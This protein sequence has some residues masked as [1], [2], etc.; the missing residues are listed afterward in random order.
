MN[1]APRL[2]AT[3]T[4]IRCAGW[5]AV[6]MI[7]PVETLV[8]RQAG[9]GA[10]ESAASSPAARTAYASAAALQNRE[11]WE[12]AAEEW[13]TLVKAHPQDPLALKGRYYL[14]ICLI[15]TDRW[16]DAERTL[17]EVIK[18]AADD[19][20]LSRARLELGRG[21]FRAAQAKP[22]PAAFA[23]A[24]D[25]LGEFLAKAAPSG[26]PADQQQ[27]A[28]AAYLAGE[29]LWQA[30]KKPEAIAAW[31]AFARERPK[32]VHHPDVLY[33]LG[34]GLAESGQ[35]EEAAR[36][37][38]QFAKQ[39]ARHALAADVTLW[40]AD[41]ATALGKPA[42]AEAL[43]APLAAGPRA[44]E[45]LERLAAA[46]LAQ[47][48]WAAA[49]ES[50]ALLAGATADA[51]RDVPPD[52]RAR[53]AELAGRAFA[54]AGRTDDART[55]FTTAMA[56]GGPAGVDAASRLAALEL[57]A[58]RPQAAFDVASAALAGASKVKDVPAPTLAGLELA[59]ADAL[60]ALEKPAE[61]A[62]AYAKVRQAH[63]Q[64]D[65]RFAWQFREGA[66]FVAAGRWKEAHEALSAAAAKLTGEPQAEALLLDATALL[67]LGQ[68]APAVTALAR[69]TREFPQ[70]SRRPEALL[71]AVRAAEQSGDTAAALAA[72]EGLVKEF[73]D[74]PNAAAVWYRLGQLRQ[75]AGRHDDAIEAYKRS[76]AKGESGAG[77]RDA[78]TAKADGERVARALLAA[79]WCHEAAG[80]LDQAIVL[81]TR[82][83]DRAPDEP[84]S[85]SA[86]LARADARLRG[87]DCAGGL[88]DTEKLLADAPRLAAVDPQAVAEARFLKGLCLAGL[89][90]HLDA[91]GEL[92]GL[93]EAAPDFAAADRALFEA[94]QALL[95]A[96]KSS[97]A[98]AVFEQLVKRFPQGEFAADAWLELGELRWADSDWA[99]A[100]AAYGQAI[101]AADGKPALAAVVEQAR[102][103]LGWTHVMRQ[104]H[105]AAAAAFRDQLA[106][107]A[108]GPLAADA[109]AL[110]GD[111]LV[112]EGRS[113]EAA[114]AFK[115]ALGDPGRLS[116]DGIRALAYVRAAECAAAREQWQESLALAERFLTAAPASPRAAEARYAA[117]WA[118]QNLGRLDEALAGYRQL[119]DAGRT[120][121]AARARLMEGE[122]LF[123]QGD[124]K[125]AIKA[126]F[127]TAY[128]FG[129]L[130]AP[131]SFHPWQAQATFEAA[132]CF[133]VLGQAEQARKLYAE[134]VERYPGCEHVPAAR[135]RLEA[136]AARAATSG[137]P[138]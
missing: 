79:G 33:A 132:R 114:A 14:A 77:T 68:P 89:G 57:D 17:R 42:D 90:R 75:A 3:S 24:A 30:G 103:K 134:L 56:A 118:R 2:V 107:A 12:L 120:E 16:P 108:D 80:R 129:E 69:I 105:A 43:V 106:A 82:L 113:E 64:A 85:L 98:A 1:R 104:D 59:R 55:W 28:E 22:S 102:H 19:E 46:R 13:A 76:A 45:A 78:A 34:V 10:A 109:A 81:W 115:K 8:A 44:G 87:G 39:H 99:K 52:Q 31:Q 9:G 15:K 91:A 128:G 49:G 65:E 95:A 6:F 47:K 67:E 100:A 110:L 74:G 53:A 93:L 125:E 36:V 83:I 135:R 40:R 111:A 54:E 92:R 138:P 96:D 20:T 51:A 127:K 21:L 41:I 122:V 29:S 123:E 26:T 11:A 25:A 72:A 7:Q 131:A 50:Y 112:S 63:P 137:T 23:A 18:S 35:R 37:L 71:L 136:L 61:A 86:R 116:S 117:A 121:L 62:A 88:A 60:W 5:L 48:K 119:A 27:A 4:I 101:K 124:H 73:P 32:S 133:E 38:E 58:G 130:G 84:A 94:G 126:F 70:W 97:E 66:A